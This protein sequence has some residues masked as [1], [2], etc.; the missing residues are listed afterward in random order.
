MP[1]GVKLYTRIAIPKKEGNLPI[2]FTR[3]PYEKAHI[4]AAHDIS[5]YENNPFIKN[6]YEMGIG[7]RLPKPKPQTMRF[8]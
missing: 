4:G 7:Q 3:T 5:E 2:V 8:I 6:G 1:D